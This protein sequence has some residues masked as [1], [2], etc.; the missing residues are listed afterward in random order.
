MVYEYKSAFAADIKAYLAFKA[1]MGVSS[2]SR[3]W[4]LF[5]FDRWCVAA[6]A[7]SFD[8]ETVEGWVVWRRERT[9]PDHLSWMSHV[10][11][12]GQWMQA[13]GNPGAYVLSDAFKSKVSRVTPYLI[14]AAEADSFFAAAAEYAVNSP[15]A[16]EARC[17]FGLMHSCGLRTC[18]A[19]RLRVCEV[20]TSAARIDIMWSKGNRSRRLAV[21][22]EV[23]EMLERCHR[24]TSELFGE[25]R[26]AFFV[27]GS[28]NPVSPALVG[29][30]FHRIWTAAGLPESKGGK[31]VRPY[32][33]RHRF[34]YANIE[35][36]G[37]EGRDVMAMMPYLARYMGH[38]GFESTYYYIH[39]SPDFLSA[40][41]GE[42]SSLDSLLPEV[43]FDD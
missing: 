7:T 36:W 40:F 35:R 39:T 27:S 31:R 11:G 14:T 4:F 9:S 34:A 10:R 43:G 17:L 15:L 21:S 28:G 13:N 29:T 5:D 1:E 38:S 3:D 25:D 22:A 2:P 6:G 23:A 42:V 16:W 8:R 24:R 20:D 32:D 19:R 18:E 30:T 37:R 12:L 41:A 33:L 26:A